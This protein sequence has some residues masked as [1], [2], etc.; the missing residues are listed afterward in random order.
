M[1]TTRE[2]LSNLKLSQS[3]ATVLEIKQH[4]LSVWEHAKMWIFKDFLRWCFN[5]DVVATLK[6]MQK[7]AD[8]YHIVGIDKSKRGCTL[9]NLTINCFHRSTFAI[10][11]FSTE[12]DIH[13]VDKTSHDM[14]TWSCNL[15][16]KKTVVDE[17][18]VRDWL[19][20]SNAFVG[21]DGS[22]LYLHSMRQAEPTRLCTRWDLGS[23][24]GG[25]TPHQ[26]KTRN[27]ECMVTSYAQRTRPQKKWTTSAR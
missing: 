18:L 22:Q 11:H 4:L 23:E 16:M 25:F 8:F 1:M 14:V 17:T 13:L 24:P 9:R 19:N 6:T 5:K 15:L 12:S 21:T 2:I 3:P 20:E 27:F 26:N 10:F 7:M